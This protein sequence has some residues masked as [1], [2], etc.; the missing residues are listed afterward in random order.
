MADALIEVSTSSGAITCTPEHKILTSRGF[1]MAKSLTTSDVVL[2]GR[3]WKIRLI[4][5]LS[6]AA[7]IGFRD[8]ITAGLD[9]STAPF[10]SMSTAW[11]QS[12]S[13]F[14][15]RT[16]SG[17]TTTSPIL[18]PSA[19][20]NT[21]EIMRWNDLER[22]RSTHQLNKPSPPPPSGMLQPRGWS[23]TVRTDGGLGSDGNGPKSRVRNALGHFAR[24][25]LRAPSTATR[26]V[27]LRRLDV[28]EAGQLVY[29][30]TV[31]N[32][33]CY[34]ANGILVSNSDAFRYLAISI[35]QTID[36]GGFSRKLVY[37]KLGVA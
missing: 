37:P 8:I 26:I 16:I 15:T 30:L 11:F 12:V 18:S 10:S 32:Q 27:R 14:I 1:V 20:Q 25:I 9:G 35:D 34:R 5:F 6:R 28:A 13:T 36:Q 3:E 4:S 33:H 24:L 7:N 21:G 19:V 2:T 22:G 29:D 31:E 17:L 23:G